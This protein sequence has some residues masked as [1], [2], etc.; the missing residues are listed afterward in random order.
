MLAY[1]QKGFYSNS[2]KNKDQSE[3]ILERSYHKRT[4]PNT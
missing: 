4:D 3:E 2:K 1:A